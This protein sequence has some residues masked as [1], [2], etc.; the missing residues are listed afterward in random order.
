MKVIAILLSFL[1]TA[2]GLK[3]Q[4]TGGST[5]GKFFRVTTFGESHGPALGVVIDGC[6][7]SIPFDV[8]DIIPELQRRRPGQSRFT[9]PRKEDDVPEILSGTTNGI[10]T[11]TPIAVMIRNK[12][13]RSHDYNEMTTK[14]RPSH[15]D[16]T[17]DAKYG[18]RE[19][20]GG[21]RSSARETVARVIAGSLAKKL[22]KIHSNTEVI[23]Y[24]KR[25]HNLT[26]IVD[27]EVVTLQMVLHSFFVYT[28][29]P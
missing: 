16:A 7:P 17:Y 22:L 4:M 9:T 11:G 14:Y 18:V 24:V 15:A 12:D 2:T 29:C 27:A 8:A 19:V 28:L 21:G 3:L 20:S 6:P 26:S 23:A 10:T 25:V 13:Q 1:V 5:F